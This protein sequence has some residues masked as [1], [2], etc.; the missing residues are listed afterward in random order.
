MKKG[1]KI[2]ILGVCKNLKWYKA[3][4]ENGTEGMVPYN[5]VQKVVATPPPVSD[6]SNA[7]PD[8]DKQAVLLKSMP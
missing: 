3:Q 7:Q 2:V 4:K 5:Y 6:D 8:K 1:D